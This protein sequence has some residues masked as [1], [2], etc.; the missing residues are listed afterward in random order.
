MRPLVIVRP[1]P[2]ASATAAAARQLGLGP[3]ILPLFELEPVEWRASDPNDFDA[4]LVTSANA[5]LFGGAELARLK[6]LPAHCVGEATAAAARDR[7]FAIAS[8]GSGGVNSLLGSL[9][10]GLRLL[11]LCGAERREPAG[12]RQVITAVPVY[13]AAAIDP[14][15]AFTS[16]REAVIAVHS[17]RAA[18]RLADISTQKEF[19]SIAAISEAAAEAAG[20]GWKQVRSAAGPTDSALLALA[21]ELCNKP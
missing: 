13:R 18:A 15:A 6:P 21:A 19:L 5:L 12:T 3:V 11:H 7:G 2:A 14:P 16:L 8:I 1:E 9:P 17:P 10:D 20:A 4:L